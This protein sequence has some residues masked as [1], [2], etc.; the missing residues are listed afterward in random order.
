MQ[1]SIGIFYDKRVRFIYFESDMHMPANL[2][3]DETR[4]SNNQRPPASPT[5]SNGKDPYLSSLSNCGVA[6]GGSSSSLQA[7][8]YIVGGWYSE[9]EKSQ[10]VVFSLIHYRKLLDS[11]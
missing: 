3:I 10:F 9:P 5:P 8:L 4:P 2:Q 1:N 6:A 7:L 11:L